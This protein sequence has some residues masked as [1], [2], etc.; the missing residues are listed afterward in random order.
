MSIRAVGLCSSVGLD[1]PSACAAIRARVSRFE[2][3]DF[4]DRA[5]EP[6]V[7]AM[8]PEAVGNRHG[9]RRLA[10]LVGEALRDCIAA[11]ATVLKGKEPKVPLLVAL[12][13]PDRLDY[14]DDLQKILALEIAPVLKGSTLK[15]P[16][17]VM[18]GPLAF[19]H[20]LR[21]AATLIEDKKADAVLV[22]A[23]DSLV[24]RRALRS[25]EARQRLKTEDHADGV[26][27]GEAAACVLVERPS[28]GTTAYPDVCGIGIAEE[29]SVQAKTP[30]LAVGLAEAI[31]EA[32]RQS[33]T[34]LAEV[35]FRVG[36]MTGE[37]SAFAEG[38]TSIARLLTVRKEDFEL[39]LPAEKLGD[40]GAAL[41]AC[42]LV[43]AAVGIAKGYA[44]GNSA[45][46]FAGSTSAERGA[47]VV[48]V[49]ERKASGR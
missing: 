34:T 42:M 21:K 29:P 31:R 18:R 17:F 9:H 43:V 14:P 45:I 11:G 39:W 46:L 12:D 1:A 48:R 15:S 25:L 33:G 23:V 2:E 44:P 35:D 13:G 22:A 6:I 26:I 3:S 47:V 40:V 30:N 27:P 24:N 32:L 5:G 41:P 16:E 36:G 10:P 49:P 28:S 38:A 37:Q 19:L 4:H 8:A 7:A 20:A